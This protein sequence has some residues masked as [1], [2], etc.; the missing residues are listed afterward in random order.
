MIKKKL[1]SVA[2]AAAM[3]TTVFATTAFAAD[4][5][6]WNNQGGSS[7]V[8]GTTYPVEP[9]IEVAI[10]GDLT[11]GINPL[12]INVSETDTPDKRQIVATDYAIINYS[13][14]QVVIDTAT[15]ATAGSGVTLLST[16]TYNTNSK[17]LDHSDSTKNV[18]LCL[19]VNKTAQ[20][21]DDA[22]KFTYGTMSETVTNESTAKAQDSLVLE[23]G[24]AE[25]VKF[26]LK[27]A[28]E[29]MEDAAASLT[30]QGAVDPQAT[31]AE[32]DITIK[33]VYTLTAVTD[34]Q[35]DGSYEADTDQ[36]TSAADTV[37][38]EK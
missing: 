32:G 38:K 7:T 33:T 35:A 25:N 24:T 37:V 6:E 21:Q 12:N 5:I 22:W 20:F 15:T 36:F 28:S 18:F 2:T 13:N 1:I 8:E 4:P 3:L 27:A 31:F 30:V 17:E 26:L 34:K 10:P 29:N 11:F 19:S 14:V 23:S 16:A 9:T